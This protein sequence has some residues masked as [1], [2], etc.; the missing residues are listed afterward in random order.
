MD[1]PKFGKI[2]RLSRDMVITEKL[3]GTNASIHILEDGTFL[4][5]SRKRWVTPEDDNFGFSAWAH[6][7]KDDLM[8]LGVGSHYGEWWGRKIQRGYGLDERRFSL[9]NTSRWNEDTKPECCHVVPVFYEGVF[10]TGIVD[11]TLEHLHV[12]GSRAAPG[13]MDPE[14]VVIFHTHSNTLFK[15]TLDHNDEHKFMWKEDPRAV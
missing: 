13:F 5:G 8:Q 9:F 1:F 11:M 6:E 4:T 2:H 12:M 15:K 10:D 7:N 14:G 3:D